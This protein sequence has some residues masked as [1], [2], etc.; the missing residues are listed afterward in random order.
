MIPDDSTRPT[1]DADPAERLLDNAEGAGAL[2][3]VED[4]L[5]AEGA[6]LS[7][8]DAMKY[9]QF[10]D[11]TKAKTPDELAA[12]IADD[13]SLIEDLIAE[14]EKQTGGEKAE[15]PNA[16]AMMEERMKSARMAEMP[17]DE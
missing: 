6:D 3:P 17:Q 12:M 16:N 5:K 9:A 15:M 8:R 7:A 13:P 11:R 2:K 1:T 14:K 4:A 10:D